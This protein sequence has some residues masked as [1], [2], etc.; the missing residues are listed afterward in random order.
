MQT[1]DMWIPSFLM[2]PHWFFKHQFLPHLQFQKVLVI[3]TLHIYIYIPI[4]SPYPPKKAP[5]SLTWY[6]INLQ[7][8]R[9]VS[10]GKRPPKSLRR[11]ARQRNAHRQ[12]PWRKFSQLPIRFSDEKHWKT[13][14]QLGCTFEYDSIVGWC[15]D[16]WFSGWCSDFFWDVRMYHCVCLMFFFQCV[17][18]LVVLF[19]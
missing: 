18:L 10:P 3:H 11:S 19:W 9:S 6:P 4:V 7:F 14:G 1:Y 15:L 8:C 12:R 16:W 2:N 5:L 17:A 13:L